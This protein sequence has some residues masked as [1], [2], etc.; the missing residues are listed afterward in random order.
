[1]LHLAVGLGLALFFLFWI[2]VIWGQPTLARL[3]TRRRARKSVTFQLPD[4][5]QLEMTRRRRKND[6]I[7]AMYR[8]AR[9]HDQERRY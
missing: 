6:T 3:V 8:V 1:M 9:E 4:M 2:V 5:A 7:Q